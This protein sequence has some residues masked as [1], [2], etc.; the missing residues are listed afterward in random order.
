MRDELIN[1]QLARHVVVH[2]IWQ[3]RTA[4]DTAKSAPFP[5]TARDELEC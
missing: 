2:Q 5:H 4:F 3:L 1:L